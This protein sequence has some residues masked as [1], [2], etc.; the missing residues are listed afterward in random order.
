MTTAEVLIGIRQRRLGRASA[1]ASRYAD[2]EYVYRDLEDAARSC[3]NWAV[4]SS[5]PKIVPLR[6]RHRKFCATMSGPILHQLI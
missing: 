5:T 4:L 1:V 6:K 2:P 3:A